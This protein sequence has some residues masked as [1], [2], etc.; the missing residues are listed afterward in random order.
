MWKNMLE[1]DTTHKPIL[2]DLILLNVFV[3]YLVENRD[4]M[5]KKSKY[6][7]KSSFN[8]LSLK[9]ILLK[10]GMTWISFT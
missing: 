9:P 6:W 2:L 5:D 10:L 3:K 4:Y 7:K 1:N 8:D